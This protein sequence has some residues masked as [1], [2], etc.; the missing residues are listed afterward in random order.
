MPAVLTRDLYIEFRQHVQSPCPDI[1]DSI[2]EGNRGLNCKLL[3]LV[4]APIRAVISTAK[5]TK[6]QRHILSNADV[7]ML[8]GPGKDKA[9]MLPGEMEFN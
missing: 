2:N 7:N 8:W 1:H 6:T 3:D 4:L 5:T 9:A